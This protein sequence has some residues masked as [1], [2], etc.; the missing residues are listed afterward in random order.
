MKNKV[1]LAASLAGVLAACGPGESA[2]TPQKPAE[3]AK[4]AVLTEP[5]HDSS[6]VI[7]VLD[8]QSVTLDHEGESTVGL[9]AGRTVFQAYADV[10]AEAPL[11][12]GARV[13]F[14]FRKAGAGYELTE[15]TAR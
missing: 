13:A 15:L 5:E 11:A 9:A 12:P 4:I 6:G 7:A 10:L 8:G 14:K 1:I 2:K 3:T